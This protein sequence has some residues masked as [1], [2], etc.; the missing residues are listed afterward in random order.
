MKKKY[1]K[2]TAAL[3]QTL[4]KILNRTAYY[5]FFHFWLIIKA[6]EVN[7]TQN[8]LVKFHTNLFTRL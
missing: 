8:Q 4:Y 6:S 1:E 2:K 3:T 5:F 7:Y